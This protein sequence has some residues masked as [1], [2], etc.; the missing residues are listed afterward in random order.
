MR[1]KA[2]VPRLKGSNMKIK[3]L[4]VSLAIL[5][6]ALTSCVGYTTP[7]EPATVPAPT[8]NPVA[9]T[10]APTSP[11]SEPSVVLQNEPPADRTW[12][13]PGKVNI[14]NYYPGGRAEYP[15]TIHNGQD[16]TASFSVLYR[17]P[18]HVGIG[19]DKPP[20]EAQDWIIIADPTPILMPKET[21]DVLVAL[22]MPKEAK[23]DSKSWEF[24]ISII[25]TTQTG[26][27][28]TELCSRWL[29][30]MR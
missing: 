14:G 30:S 12:V 27:V 11:T 23:I 1:L 8:E 15:V 5:A 16:I 10:P 26:A 9:E 18:D 29:V 20:L 19:Y 24:W 13:S 22:V 28:R 25:D 6:M 7:A 3:I 17:Y 4:A 2:Q 21:R